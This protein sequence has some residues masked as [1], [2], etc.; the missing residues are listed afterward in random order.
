[1]TTPPTPRQL[2][3]QLCALLGVEPLGGDVYEGA[4]TPAGAETGAGRVFGGQVIAQALAAAE[5]TVPEGRPP[6]SLHAY[7]LRMGD[8]QRPIRYEVA[9][10]L[11][12]GSFANRR[13]L[14]RQDADGGGRLLLSL[15]ASF[16]RI[17]QGVSHQDAMPQVPG[18]EGLASEY[19]RRLARA[20]LYPE[21]R[22][23]GISAPRPIEQRAVEPIDLLDPVPGPPAMH[24]WFRAAAPLGDDPR[25]HR[26]I[27]AYAS[28]FSL[29]PTATRPHGLSWFRG[30]IQ[31]A[32]LDHA[33]WFH[34]DFRADE[35]LL[36]ET[37]SAWAGRGRGHVTGRIFRRDGRLVA[38]V[39]QEGMMRVVTRG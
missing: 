32:S 7:F 11:D 21:H 4:R 16:H 27:L 37:H 12:G 31:E 10:D 17:E 29:L 22:R 2:V 14:A 24:T 39:A 3:D 9:R 13:V 5:A 20:H 38:S 18:P 34:D 8:D 6:H 19:E 15:S 36:Y 25:L 1:M 28:D 30:E 35:W 26:A 23:R 33:I